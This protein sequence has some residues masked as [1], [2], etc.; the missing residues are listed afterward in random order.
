MGG[1][2]QKLWVVEDMKDQE[3]RNEC[4]PRTVTPKSASFW[5][6]IVQGAEVL[7]QPTKKMLQHLSRGASK[8]A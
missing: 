4:T 1:I 7:D 3:D 8:E 5:P 6:D 2:W